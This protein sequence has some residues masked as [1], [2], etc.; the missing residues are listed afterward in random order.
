MKKFLLFLILFLHFHAAQAASQLKVTALQEFTTEKPSESIVVALNDDSQLGE[1]NFSA[2][3]VLTCRVFNIIEP[4]RGKRDASFYVIPVYYSVDEKLMRIE[5]EMYGKYAKRVLSKEEL[6]KIP[7]FKTFKKAALSV[8]NYFVK[9]LST[10]YAFVE[11]IVKNEK[12]GRIKSG[13]VNAYEESPLS[14]ISE[15]EQLNI[16]PGDEFYFVFRTASDD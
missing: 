9:G 5:Q 10:S 3:T 14:L 12:D 13:V 4:K 6:K 16:Q 11:G 15:G 8:G 2:N 7:S 1:Y